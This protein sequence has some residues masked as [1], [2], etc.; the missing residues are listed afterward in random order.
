MANTYLISTDQIKSSTYIDE[1]VSDKM[2][3]V[4]I[5]DC[6]QQILEPLIGSSLYDHLID[7]V[8]NATLDANHQELLVKYIWP[9]LQQGTIFKLAYNLLY[10]I[11][12][13]S[14]VKDSNENSSAITTQEVN[15]L[16][17]ERELSMQ[18]HIKK[19]TKHLI[20]YAGTKY[21]SYNAQVAID[22]VGPDQTVNSMSVWYYDE[23]I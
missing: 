23:S 19:L 13:S 6:Q 22:G 3:K 11:T 17:K 4:S 21:P 20:A 10:R 7:G 18:Y 14:V 16:I 8:T 12:N 1:N 9:V 2:L 5:L 15:V